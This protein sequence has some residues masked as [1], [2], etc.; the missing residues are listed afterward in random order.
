MT[1]TD[2]W[3]VRKQ[4]IIINILIDLTGTFRHLINLY[5]LHFMHAALSLL[6]LHV[7][8]FSRNYFLGRQQGNRISFLN[9]F[10]PFI[11]NKFTDN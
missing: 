7:L 1:E 10:I 11:A 5:H 3:K 4:V 6:I 9:F 8:I 2:A